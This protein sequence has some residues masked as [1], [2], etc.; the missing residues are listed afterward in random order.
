[1]PNNEHLDIKDIRLMFECFKKQNINF[2]EILFTEYKIINPLFK[3]MF[4][5][6]ISCR[7]QIARYNMFAAVNCISG[8]SMEKLKAMEHP[9]PATMDKIEKFR[10][11]PK[12]LHHILRLNEFMRRYIEG[13]PYKNCL[14]SKDR[15]FLLDI[16][17]GILDLGVARVVAVNMDKITKEIKDKFMQNN[18]PFV[19]KEIDELF[20][21]VLYDILRFNFQKEL[22]EGD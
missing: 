8:M 21:N 6:I 14:K 22:S 18:T 15:D 9:Y 17:R 4:Q 12:Q 11:D 19:D 1:M 10:Y 13:E 3:R 5:P 16:K 7:E 2:V 20:D